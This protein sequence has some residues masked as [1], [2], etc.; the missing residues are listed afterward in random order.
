M[1]Q[2]TSGHFEAVSRRRNMLWRKNAV[3]RPIPRRRV[4]ALLPSGPDGIAHGV[5][6]DRVPQEA[7]EQPI[8]LRWGRRVH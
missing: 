7:C 6:R 8:A 5:D 4:G 3:G 1:K 2:V